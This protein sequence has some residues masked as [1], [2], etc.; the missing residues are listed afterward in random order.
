MSDITRRQILTVGSIGVAGVASAIAAGQA[1][2]NTQ[3][4][5]AHTQLERLQP[6]QVLRSP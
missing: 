5:V 3:K 1:Q 4:P 2:A 6:V